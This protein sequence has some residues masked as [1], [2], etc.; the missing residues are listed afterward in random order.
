[1]AIKL[2]LVSVDIPARATID[3]VCQVLLTGSYPSGGETVDFSTLAGQQS[4]EGGMLDSDLLPSYAYAESIA[5]QFGYNYAVQLYTA[6]AVPVPL[7]WK[8]CKLRV[9]YTQ[10]GLGTIATEFSAGVYPSAILQ[11]Y[12]T[13]VARFWRER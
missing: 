10:V 7:T 1:M 12:I 5:A 2:A 6:A 9:L 11:D 13:L 8:T 4:Q 3:I